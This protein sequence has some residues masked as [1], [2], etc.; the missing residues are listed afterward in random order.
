[1][2]VFLLFVVMPFFCGLIGSILAIVAAI[3]LHNELRRTKRGLHTSL[4]LSIALVILVLITI[5]WGFLWILIFENIESGNLPHFGFGIFGINFFGAIILGC[6][7]GIA[8]FISYFISK[9]KKI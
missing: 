3:T 5:G 7:P 2:G 6:L 8:I 4:F 9:I 1:M